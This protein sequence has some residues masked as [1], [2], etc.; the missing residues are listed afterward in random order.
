VPVE[1][2]QQVIGVL[3]VFSTSTHAFSQDDERLLLLFANLAAVAMEN[4]ALIAETQFRLHKLQVLH[5]IELAVAGTFDLHVILDIIVKQATLKFGI[6]ATTILLFNPPS[7]K[8]VYAAGEGFYTKTLQHSTLR[9]GD[10]YA[11]MAAL[12]RKVII[13]PDL[14]NRLT[15]FLRS[16]QFA[17]E[18]FVTYYAFPLIC[19]GQLKGVLEIFFRSLQQKEQDWLDFISS[20]ANQAAIAIDRAHL[21]TSLQNANIEMRRTCTEMLEGW[22]RALDLR[23]QESPGHTQRVAHATMIL[24]QQMGINKEDLEHIYQGALLHDIGFMGIPDTILKKSNPLTPEEQ[25]RIYQHPV[26]AYKLLSSIAFIRQALDIP[27]CHHEKWD[28]SGYPSGLQGERIPIAARIFAVV[29]VWY[30][31]TSDRPYRKAWTSNQ[32]LTYIRMQAGS[33]FDPAV[34]EVFLDTITSSEIAK[35]V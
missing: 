33:H 19:K 24:A 5:D 11:G 32:A 28:G 10:G 3:G 21:F 15:D 23:D 14:R 22:A 7:S 2:N 29:D 26:L 25:E 8:L 17:R 20:L 30:A 13:V 4:S 6:D 12:D 34:V 27:Y 18:G 35:L 31:L 9:L 1:R 16:P